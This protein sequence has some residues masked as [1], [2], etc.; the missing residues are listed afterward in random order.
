MPRFLS[1]FAF[2]LLL[3]LSACNAQ[4]DNTVA[5]VEKALGE[6]KAGIHYEVLSP[7]I[8]TRDSNKIELLEAFWYGCI[9]CFQLEP[10]LKALLATLPDDVDM[11]HLPA[12]WA[13]GMDTHAKF[14]YSAVALG[15][16]DKLH[17]PMFDAMNLKKKRML[18]DDE[19]FSLVKKQGVDVE[20]FRR[21]FSSFGIE[22]QVNQIRSKMGQYRITGT[23]ELV[24]NGKYH[25]TAKMAGSTDKMLELAAL[26]IEQ[27]RIVKA[28]AQ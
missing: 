4:S 19:I 28:S 20:K 22:S 12:V 18:K 5:D 7:A 10:K 11:V 6:Y 26:L 17:Q 15:E 3:P 16:L 8:P 13:Q 25:L 24:V 23:P 1:I 27:E 9:H 14:Y 2:A 21:A